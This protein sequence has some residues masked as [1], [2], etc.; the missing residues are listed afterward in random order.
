MKKIVLLIL[1]LAVMP[2]SVSADRT[3]QISLTLNNTDANVYIPGQGEIAAGSLSSATYY[4]MPHYYAC[5]YDSD[6]LAGLVHSQKTP[7]SI[8]VSSGNGLYTIALNQSFENSMAFVVF[9]RGDWRKIDNV[10]DLI[11]EGIFLEKPKP[12]FGFGLGRTYE[13]K[14]MLKYDLVDFIGNRGVLSKGDRTV[15]VTNNGTVSSKAGI[16]IRPM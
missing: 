7:Y 13:I 6:F 5:S 1:M 11:E 8:S 15:V 3:L 16:L 10:I 2:A 9:S 4:N 14:M 12:S